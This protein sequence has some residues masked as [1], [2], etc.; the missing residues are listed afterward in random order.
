MTRIARMGNGAG[1]FSSSCVGS[2][3]LRPADLADARV[4]AQVKEL[5]KEVNDIADPVA[6]RAS[7][8]AWRLR[9]ARR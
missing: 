4:D 5:D 8:A 1:W 7:P 2:G 6:P 3:P 9:Q